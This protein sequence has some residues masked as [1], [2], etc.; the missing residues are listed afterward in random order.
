MDF[1]LRKQPNKSQALQAGYLSALYHHLS[2]DECIGIVISLVIVLT[3]RA[4]TRLATACEES[5]LTIITGIS[6][7]LAHCAQHQQRNYTGSLLLSLTAEV[8]AFIDF[9]LVV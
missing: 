5:C 4:W 9:G 7:V 3:K 6:C 8:L 1:W 2:K